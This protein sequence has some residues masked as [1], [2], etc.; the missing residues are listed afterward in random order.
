[1]LCH[2]K[3]TPERASILNTIMTYCQYFRFTLLITIFW[4][5]MEEMCNICSIYTFYVLLFEELKYLLLSYQRKFVRVPLQISNLGNT[6][7]TDYKL[8]PPD[9]SVYRSPA[10]GR[11]V[12]SIEWVFVVLERAKCCSCFTVNSVGI[13]ASTCDCVCIFLIFQVFVFPTLIFY[14]FTTL[15]LLLTL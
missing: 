6:S 14:I 11:I 5:I 8:V 7:N 1:M 15:P 9:P 12:N 10:I 4:K 2:T 3:I 13:V